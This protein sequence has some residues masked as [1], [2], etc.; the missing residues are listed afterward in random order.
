MIS[1]G[2]RSFDLSPYSYPEIEPIP[3]Y[4]DQGDKTMRNLEFRS[5][6]ESVKFWLSYGCTERMAQDNA[7]AEKRV[8][9][10]GWKIRFE[11]E[12]EE[13]DGDEDCPRPL[14]VLWAA[15]EDSEG[16]LLESLGM[17]GVDSLT[18]PY[19]RDVKS[20]LVHEALHNYDFA[21]NALNEAIA[22]S[23]ASRVTY[24]G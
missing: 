18:D 11:D 2:E 20:Q 4:S 22:E 17:I 9:D 14:Y 5:I 21:R 6:E 19:L 10:L 12:D 23:M 16:H 15:L 7:L 3:E 24:A 1:E 8:D 13:W